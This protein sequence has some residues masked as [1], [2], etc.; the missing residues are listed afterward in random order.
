MKKWLI[1]MMALLGTVSVVVLFTIQ[2]EGASSKGQEDLSKTVIERYTIDL[3]QQREH[4]YNR[5]L[6]LG[7]L[8]EQQVKVVNEEIKHYLQQLEKIKATMQTT[9]IYT[10]N[11]NVRN[12]IDLEIL[13]MTK[14]LK[15]LAT[16]DET[17]L[18]DI[19]EMY[20]SLLKYQKEIS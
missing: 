13:L 5:I 12:S 1:G 17:Y 18:V 6:L 9:E 3:Q 11:D 2:Q 15:A 20:H 7:T 8:E 14:I 4:C 10:N 19:S 16:K